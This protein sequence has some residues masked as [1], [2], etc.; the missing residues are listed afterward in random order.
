[1]STFIEKTFL[2]A[3]DTVAK[4]N[5]KNQTITFLKNNIHKIS[6][7]TKISAEQFSQIYWKKEEIHPD[8]KYLFE[9]NLS[10]S[11]IKRMIDERYGGLLFSYRT[12]A[13]ESYYW[14][15]INLFVPDEDEVTDILICRRRIRQASADMMETLERFNRKIYKVMKCNLTNGSSRIIRQRVSEDYMRIKHKKTFRV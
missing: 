7:N 6:P 3:F 1:M 15:N 5:I 10:P 13:G 14:S 12:L 2:S 9:I 4:I 8:D 11:T